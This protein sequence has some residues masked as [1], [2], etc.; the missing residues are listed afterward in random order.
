[1]RGFTLLECLLYIALFGIIISGAAVGMVAISESAD[2]N[3][4]KALLEDE[5]SYLIAKIQ[6]ETEAGMLP[7]ISISGSRLIQTEGTAALPLSD[8]TLS[9]TAASLQEKDVGN[10][11]QRAIIISLT[12]SATTSAGRIISQSFSGTSYVLP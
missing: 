9:V 4:T 6:R 1:M 10:P 7:A 12:L 3:A 5:G 8:S 11:I 2:R